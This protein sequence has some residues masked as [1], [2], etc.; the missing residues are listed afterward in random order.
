MKRATYIA[1]FRALTLEV[2]MIVATPCN[3]LAI[4]PMGVDSLAPPDPFR[5]LFASEEKSKKSNDEGA[6]RLYKNPS[7]FEMNEE[8]AKLWSTLQKVHKERFKPG[9]PIKAV[10]EVLFF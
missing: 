9:S 2:D 5:E 1:F 6:D 4:M 10:N 7:R 8:E 3:N